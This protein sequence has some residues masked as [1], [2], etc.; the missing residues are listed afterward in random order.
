[1]KFEN[2]EE[3]KIWYEGHKAILRDQ[4]EKAIKEHW[5]NLNKFEN[6]EQV[7]DLPVADKEEWTNFYIPRLIECGAIPKKDLVHGR[8]YIGSH[9]R[10]SV[11]RWDADKEKFIYWRYKFGF[12]IDDCNHFEDD[13]GF[14][15]F[16]PIRET[17]KEEFDKTSKD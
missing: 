13:N 6:E 12:Y 10:A 17:N 8:Y 3:A 15:L 1:M 14:A 2:K 9:R 4:R 7:P 11:A 16:V 5:K